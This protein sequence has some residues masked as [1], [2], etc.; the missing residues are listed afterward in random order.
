MVTNQED[1]QTSKYVQLFFIDLFSSQGITEGREEK[2]Q[3]IPTL[4]TEDMNS[5]LTTPISEE[6][7]CIACFSMK[8][9]K[10]PGPDGFSPC[11]FQQI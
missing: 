3:A 6:E 2:L 9:S 8:P 1:I 4:V 7:V 5:L 11:F 10:A